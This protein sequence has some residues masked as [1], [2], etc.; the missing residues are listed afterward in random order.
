MLVGEGS[1]KVASYIF[2]KPS[3]LGS[4]RKYDV[5]IY[6][7]IRDVQGP[8]RNDICT[9]MLEWNSSVRKARMERGDREPTEHVEWTRMQLKAY[10][11][12][13]QAWGPKRW[14]GY[15]PNRGLGKVLAWE[16][17]A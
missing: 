5:Y 13:P 6:K 2:H 1:V 8:E 11:W 17:Q 14:L 9:R 12:G 16:L 10:A 15:T 3:G 4:T 7:C